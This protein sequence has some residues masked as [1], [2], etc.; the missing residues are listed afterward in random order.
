MIS[1]TK[2]SSKLA[3]I[4]M[5]I[6]ALFLGFQGFKQFSN[7]KKIESQKKALQEQADSLIKKNEDLNKSLAYIN[8]PSFKERVARQQLNL[9]KDGETV[10][11]FSDTPAT[12]NSN[13]A[14]QAGETNFIK[15]WN[16]FFSNK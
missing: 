3:I 9:K 12:D 1:K 13:E 2:I 5:L 15:W 4:S 10:Y 7:Q 6:L 16:Y 14:K 8:S 11:S